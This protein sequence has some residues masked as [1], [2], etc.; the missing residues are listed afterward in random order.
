MRNA[1]L[2]DLGGM[3]VLVTG[4]SGGIGGGIARRFAAAGARVAVHYSGT[5]A[6]SEAR[7]LALVDELRECAAARRGAAAGSDAA[8]GGADRGVAV[9]V[10]ADL[11]RPGAAAE[12]VA[13]AADAL[14][15]LDGLVN[16][17]GIQPLAPLA[18][19]SR[20][21]WD[22]VLATNLGAVFELSR[23]AAALMAVPAADPD[24]DADAVGAVRAGAVRADAVGTEAGAHADRWI[25]HIAS[26]EASRPAPAHAHYAAAKAGVVMHARAAA[27]ELGPLGIRVNTVSPGLVDRPG[28]A[29]VWPEGVASWLARAPLG[30]LAT[31]EDVGDACVLLASP[32]ASFITGQD[33]AVDGGMLATPGW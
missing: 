32:A 31:A 33:L 4:A 25:T 28:L 22:E 14:G 20:A 18:Q 19:T 29:E 7:A 12:L 23:E 30:R 17:A 21:A 24:A 16:N 2:P 27:L 9:A 11:A 6:A 8:T 13:E 3:R 26:I 10:G 15:G 1:A 5:S